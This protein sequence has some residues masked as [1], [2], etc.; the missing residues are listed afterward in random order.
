MET[1]K[2]IF[3]RVNQWVKTSIGLRI[4]TITFLVL[5]LLIPVN[6]V[7]DLIRERGYRQEEAVREVSQKWGEEQTVSGPVL[8]IPYHIYSTI[9]EE[10][11]KGEKT[12]KVIKTKKRAHFL[13]SKLN[14][15]GDLQPETRHRG[16]YEIIVYNSSVQIFGEFEKPDFKKLNI[17]ENNILWS[18]A[19]LSI[20]LSDLRSIQKKINLKWN[21]QFYPF[22]PGL[23]STDVIKRGVT[24]AIPLNKLTLENSY[25][26]EI[27]LDFN[28]SKG[29]NFLPFGRT[30]KV[31]ISSPWKDPKFKGAFLP[32]ASNVS[33]DGFQAEWEVLHLNR[34]YPQEFTGAIKNV[35]ASAFG[36]DLLMPVGQYQKSTRSVK[37]AVLF[38]GLT[39]LVFFFVQIINNV[40]IHPIQYLL[41]GLALCLF[42]TLLVSLSEHIS[43]MYSYLSASIAIIL[44][45]TGFA[46]SIFKETKLTLILAGIMT[47]LYGFIYII[48]QLQDYS[49][50][51][52][53]AGLIAILGGVM[54]LSRNIDWYN[55]NKKE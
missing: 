55:S 43:F 33:T 18:E 28:G 19:S 6:M 41:V 5:I 31:K 47:F 32:D 2:T 53:S 27:A 26:F 49:L 11:S 35:S 30:T 46:K 3:D 17:D 13:P 54:Y 50:L 16:I 7:E 34:D 48:I 25:Q 20:G 21:K 36:V 1:T 37:Y 4:F 29:I 22:E 23:N 44:M 24:T 40:R 15:E 52:G 42:F 14:V 38:I 51:V 8:T 9:T 39:F 12:E 10:N 45:I